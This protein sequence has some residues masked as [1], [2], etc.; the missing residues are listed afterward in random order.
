MAPKKLLSTEGESPRPLYP[1]HRMGFN[2]DNEQD[3]EYIPPGATTPTPTS[4]ITR[5]NP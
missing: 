2:S 5:G 1:S 3:L 4:Q